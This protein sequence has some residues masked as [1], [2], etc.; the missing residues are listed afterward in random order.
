MRRDATTLGHDVSRVAYILTRER[1]KMSKHCQWCGE[2]FVKNATMFLDYH[3]L[4]WKQNKEAIE[5]LEKQEDDNSERV[6][7]LEKRVNHLEELLLE[8]SAGSKLLKRRPS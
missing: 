4:C 6:D 2:E 5:S 1:N 7:F 8:S 3:E